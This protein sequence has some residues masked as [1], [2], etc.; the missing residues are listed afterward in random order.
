MGQDCTN[1]HIENCR[2]ANRSFLYS[3]QSQSALFKPGM[4]S[5]FR[6]IVYGGEEYYLSVDGHGKLG[7]I[8]VRIFEDEKKE[9]ALYDN[10]EF[11]YEKYFYFKNSRTRDLVVEVTS[12]NTDSGSSSNQRYCLGVLIEF[13]ETEAREK[14]LQDTVGF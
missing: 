12:K 5:E 1:Y 4:R 7:D 11:N 13:R 2:W 14:R 10:A 3:R 9:Q 6:I 8:R